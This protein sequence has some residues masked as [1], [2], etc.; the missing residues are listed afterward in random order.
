MVLTNPFSRA[1]PRVQFTSTKP[2][3]VL[4]PSSCGIEFGMACAPTSVGD[5]FT[6]TA[7][8]AVDTLFTC[9]ITFM[10]N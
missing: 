5:N 9:A 1:D 4:G 8:L 3:F 10:V 7:F 6:R 2:T